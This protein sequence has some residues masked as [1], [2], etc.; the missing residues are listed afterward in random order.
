MFLYMTL[1]FCF[2]FALTNT[3][4]RNESHVLCKSADNVELNLNS[5]F[6]VSAEFAI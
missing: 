2:Q 3:T 1:A 5:L 6:A 4:F